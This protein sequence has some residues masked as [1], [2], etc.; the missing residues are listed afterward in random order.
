MFQD[1]TALDTAGRLCI[2]FFFLAAGIGNMTPQKIKDHIDRMA[3]AHTPLPTLAFWFGIFL[4]FSGCALLL[5]GW[6]ADIG[7]C[8]LIVFT[9]AATAIFHR[10]WQ[11]SD[12][13]RRNISRIMFLNNTAILGG[14]FLLLQN[15]L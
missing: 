12:P 2:V 1:A 7:V 15:V 6:H 4:Q 14:L 11:V 9:I 13:M 5:T 3:A 8:L 10:F